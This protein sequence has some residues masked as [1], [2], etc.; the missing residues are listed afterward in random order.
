[1]QLKKKKC[2]TV[3]KEG[4]TRNN[5]R[6][7]EERRCRKEEGEDK[8]ERKGIIFKRRKGNIKKRQRRTRKSYGQ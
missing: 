2:R 6:Y 3:R 5:V 4:R 1:M 8:R 7:E